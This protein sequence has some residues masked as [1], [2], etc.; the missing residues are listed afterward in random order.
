MCT[1]L[2]VRIQYH[3]HSWWVNIVF[4][5]PVYILHL[6]YHMHKQGVF[7]GGNW[8]CTEKRGERASCSLPLRACCFPPL[9]RSQ[10]G[11]SHQNQRPS[12][13]AGQTPPREKKRRERRLLLP[14]SNDH[15]HVTFQDE[16]E[17]EG[18]GKKRGGGETAVCSP[19]DEL[20]CRS[21]SGAEMRK[22]FF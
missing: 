18:G 19:R 3:Q 10:E 16:E 7:K 14:P 22:D 17:E 5:L 1:T 4:L 2:T 6:E 15:Q 8:A 21:Q 13:R 11:G 12:L 20:A 9:V